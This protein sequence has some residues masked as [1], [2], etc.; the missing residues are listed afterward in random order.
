MNEGKQM[1]KVSKEKR[2]KETRCVISIYFVHIISFPH[3]HVFFLNLKYQNSVS[4]LIQCYCAKCVC[5][6]AYECL[7]TYVCINITTYLS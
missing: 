3:V 2:K 6:S 7:H 1:I 5:L 4:D